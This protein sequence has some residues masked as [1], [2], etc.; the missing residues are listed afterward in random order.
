MQVER[1]PLTDYATCF[2]PVQADNKKLAGET[3]ATLDSSRL[4]VTDYAC[5][6]RQKLSFPLWIPDECFKFGSILRIF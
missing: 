5:I 2:W 3:A 1:R 4:P 6:S